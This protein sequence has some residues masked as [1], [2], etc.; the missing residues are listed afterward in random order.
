MSANETVASA[1]AGRQVI[2]EFTGTD[3][4]KIFNLAHAKIVSIHWVADGV[5]GKAAFTATGVTVEF[6]S[7]ARKGQATAGAIRGKTKTSLLIVV[8]VGETTVI[9]DEEESMMAA[10]QDLCVLISSASETGFV[11]LGLTP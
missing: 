6:R 3:T 2:V 7:L 5:E 9:S 10:G 8:A 11:A 1:A 4:S